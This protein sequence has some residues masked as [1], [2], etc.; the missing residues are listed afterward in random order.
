[1][2]DPNHPYAHLLSAAEKK[3]CGA[4]FGYLKTVNEQDLSIAKVMAGASTGESTLGDIKEA[5]KFARSVED[6]GYFGDY[7][8][9]T[10][11]EIFSDIHTKIQ[12]C[13][14]L[15]DSAFDEYLAYW[16][17]SNVAHIESGTTTLK[18]AIVVTDECI[19]DLTVTLDTLARHRMTKAK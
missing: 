1:M 11:L 6:A 16:N 13:K 19:H 14:K 9:A 18:R 2:V 10:A 3:Y 5:I 15:H 12:S 4:A 7:Q 17:D 8:S